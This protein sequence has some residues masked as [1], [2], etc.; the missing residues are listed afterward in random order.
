MALLRCAAAASHDCGGGSGRAQ[1]LGSRRLRN[2]RQH[3]AEIR[4]GGD[5]KECHFVC[6]TGCSHTTAPVQYRN[7]IAAALKRTRY[8]LCSEW[9]PK[10]NA[11]MR[12]VFVTSTLAS[13]MAMAAGAPTAPNFDPKATAPLARAIMEGVIL[14]S[15][16]WPS[17]PVDVQARL[18]LRSTVCD[19]AG[20]CF[21]GLED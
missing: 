8:A 10:K 14:G 17:T 3:H 2:S 6:L 21:W 12:R 4:S 5:R 7:C 13:A 19:A 9:R 11:P 16:A 15:S 20:R 18:Q 1:F